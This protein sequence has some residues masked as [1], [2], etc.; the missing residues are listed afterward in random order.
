MWL[1]DTVGAL[2]PIPSSSFLPGF[3]RLASIPQSAVWDLASEGQTEDSLSR[4]SSC[5][6]LSQHYL[7][8]GWVPWGDKETWCGSLWEAGSPSFP[9]LQPLR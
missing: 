3:Y 8:V 4:N 9:S 2:F 6:I 5:F 1:L 7:E